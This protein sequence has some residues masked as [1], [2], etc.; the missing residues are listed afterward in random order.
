M[1]I[2]TISR[3]SYS[4]G[5]ETAEKLA[6]EFGYACISREILLMAS[7]QFHV[8]EIKLIRAIHDSPTILDRYTYGKEKYIAY[9]RSVLLN[10]MRNDNIIYHGFAGHVFLDDISHVLKVRIIADLEK[11]IEIVMKRDHV[12]EK[13]A[14]QILKKDDEER[15]KWSLRL[16]GINTADAKLYDMVL[17]IGKLTVNDAVDIISRAAKRACFQK[18]PESQQMLENLILASKIE[19][20]LVEEFPT[21]KA[22]ADNGDIRILVKAPLAEAHLITERIEERLGKMTEVGAVTVKVKP[23]VLDVNF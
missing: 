13:K 15:Q 8:P 7:E 6:E 16:Y 17:H 2:I 21:I 14:R 20:E 18:T 10:R 22:V 3:G 1:S 19:A 23:F 11:R 4:Y 12:D 9:I 5:K